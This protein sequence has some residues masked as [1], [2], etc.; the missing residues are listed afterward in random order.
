MRILALDYGKKRIG[1]AVGD[2][3]DGIAFPRRALFGTS[4]P[5]MTGLYE[6]ILMFISTEPVG[7]ILVGYPGDISGSGSSQCEESRFFADS[8]E[9]YLLEHNNPC[10]VEFA[11]EILSSQI[12]AHKL[13]EAGIAPSRM[14]GEKDSLAAAVF[15]QTYLD[16]FSS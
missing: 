13:R 1:I 12:A 10:P 15:L 7:K 4:D 11:N 5:H 14:S 9:D 16:Q 3:V 6:S 8:L 2:T